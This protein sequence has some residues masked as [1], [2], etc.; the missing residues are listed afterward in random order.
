VRALVF[1]FASLLETTGRELMTGL[2]VSQ[3]VRLTGAAS[4]FRGLRVPF[5]SFQKTNPRPR[6]N[7]RRERLKTALENSLQQSFE[8]EDE[9]SPEIDP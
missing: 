8:V 1:S 5:L 2:F 9:I 3:R 6:Q 7:V 4:G